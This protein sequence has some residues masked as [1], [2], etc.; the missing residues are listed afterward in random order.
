MFRQLHFG[1]KAWL[2][3]LAFLVPLM[4][5]CGAYYRTSQLTIDFARSELVGVDVVQSLEPW[6]IAAQKQ[7]RLVM[8]GMAPRVDLSAVEDA[9]Q[10]FRKLSKTL[11]ASINLHEGVAAVEAAHAALV[12]GGVDAGSPDLE[13][14]MQRLVTELVALRDLTLDTSGL[15]LDPDQDTYYLMTLSGPLISDVIEDISRS[16]AISGSLQGTASLATP[17]AIRQLYGYWFHGSDALGDVRNAVRHAGQFNAQVRERLDAE[18]AGQAA[19]AFFAA[20]QRRWFGDEFKADVEGLNSVGQTAVD[21]LRALSGR[22]NVL[23]KDLLEQRVASTQNAR[24]WIL[25]VTALC[26]LVAAY[27]FFSFYLVMRG[28]LRE[29]GRHLEAMTAGDLTTRPSPWGRDEAAQLMLL[30]ATMQDSLRAMV[31]QV[32][33]SS[34]GM[35]S[36]SSE[37]AAAS[38][39]LSARTEQAAA[40][41]EES[42]SAMEQIGANVRSTADST[43]EATRMAGSNASLAANGG[44]IMAELAETMKAIDDS[45]HRIGDITAMIDSIAFQTNILALNAAVEAARAGEQGRGFAVVAT[46]VRTLAGRSAEAAREIKTLINTSMDTVRR[47]STVTQEARQAIGSIVDGAGH[48]DR[49]LRDVAAGT[50]AQTDGISQVGAAIQ[51]LDQATQQNAAMVEQTAAAAASMRD[52][53]QQLAAQVEK[54]RLPATTR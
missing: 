37:I 43:D 34:L 35:V 6:L 51:D 3:T 13:S 50:R 29:V 21:E 48:M 41:L 12:Q 11:P 54:F 9:A 28:G 14:R 49:L 44:T 2:I 20:A 31:V 1:A 27:L 26:L 52:Q 15:T 19:D 47:G 45:A 42:S 17:A 4:L 39:D 8:S 18:R 10:A 32:R 22:S 40:N 33:E 16:S 5:L 30:L 38:S 25:A 46:E 23:L 36:A 24:Q 53:A 7:R